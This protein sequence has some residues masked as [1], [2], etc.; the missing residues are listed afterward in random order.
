M[1]PEGVLMVRPRCFGYNPETAESNAF[2]QNT[3]L[4]QASFLARAEFDCMVE[5]LSNAGVKVLVAS[6]PDEPCSDAVFPNNWLA[7]MP[8]GTLIVFPMMAPGRRKE[9]NEPTIELL[10]H[11]TLSKHTIDLRHHADVGR[12]LEGTGSIVFDHAFRIAYACVSPRTDIKLFSMLCK[13]INYDAVSFR[14]TDI[15]GQEIYH[16]NVVMSV[17]ANRVILCDEAVEDPLE[18]S[19]LKERIKRSGKE[20][21]I[22]SL[23]QMQAFA[24]NAFEVRC[25][26]DHCWIFS[27]TAWNALT[28][29]QQES[30]KSDGKICVVSIPTIEQLGGGSAR[31]MVAGFYAA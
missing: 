17:G 25:G 19:M 20:L 9:V 31:C 8:D 28:A 7:C 4:E 22:I 23:A 11:H 2:Q 30:L 10:R 3:D 5:A 24:A 26:E 6:D 14:A 15:R 27:E 1:I 13:D 12:Y 29:D 18:R 16:T 21:L